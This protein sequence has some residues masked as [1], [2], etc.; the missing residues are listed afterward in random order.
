M[1]NTKKP[2]AVLVT[3]RTFCDL[4]FSKVQ[5]YR[6]SAKLKDSVGYVK[7]T[8]SY[9]LYA[10]DDKSRQIVVL[11]DSPTS[12]DFNEHVTARAKAEACARYDFI[13]EYRDAGTRTNPKV[14]MLVWELN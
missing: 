3:D 4:Y 2:K 12:A 1:P 14:T 10:V 6:N 5:E 7:G 13:V 9:C 11:A 8:A